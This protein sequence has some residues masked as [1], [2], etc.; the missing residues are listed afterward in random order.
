[1]PY[2]IGKSGVYHVKTKSKKGG[3]KHRKT[4]KTKSSALKA[5]HHRRRFK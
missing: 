5:C 2:R 1:M 4:F 3:R